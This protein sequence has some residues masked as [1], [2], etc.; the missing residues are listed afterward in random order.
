[1]RAEHHAQVAEIENASLAL[2]TSDARTSLTVDRL[3]E[4][5]TRSW[6]R[7]WVARDGERVAGYLMAWHVADELHVLDVA[8][9]PTQRR[10]GVARA[11]LEEAR[12]YAVS[13]RLVQVLLE[14]RRSNAA[15][16]ALYKGGGFFARNVRRGYYSDGEDAVDMALLLEPGT[17]RTLA[18][19]D[20]VE[21]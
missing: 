19:A 6:S 11:L 3:R 10:R 1:M 4:E 17:G 16:I 14:V 5:Q 13:R 8:T 20:E 7:C 9:H 15:A 18:R 2:Q 21:I 12:R